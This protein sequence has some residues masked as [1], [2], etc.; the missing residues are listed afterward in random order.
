MAVGLAN[1]SCVDSVVKA[2]SVGAKMVRL[3]F[4]LPKVA[5]K[6][7]LSAAASNAVKPLFFATSA[8]VAWLVEPPPQ[9]DKKAARPSAEIHF[10][11]VIISI[12]MCG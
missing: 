6:P 5:D 2:A 11:K 7:A 10:K 12:S 1:P 4:A 8:R 3:A 9:A